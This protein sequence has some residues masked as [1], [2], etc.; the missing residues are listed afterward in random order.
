MSPT[1]SDWRPVL[2]RDN[3]LQDGDRLPTPP[4]QYTLDIERL[5]EQNLVTSRIRPK[6]RL[7][8]VDLST[9]GLNRLGLHR[10]NLID[11]R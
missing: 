2:W 1:K 3:G 11:T 4:G 8:A 6:R 10:T 7:Q 9:K 5:R